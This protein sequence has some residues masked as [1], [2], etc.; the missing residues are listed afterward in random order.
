MNEDNFSPQRENDMIKRRVNFRIAGS[1]CLALE[2]FLTW[3]TDLE[4]EG[5]MTRFTNDDVKYFAEFAKLAMSDEEAAVYA[6]KLSELA[7]FAEELKEVDTEGIAPM[8]HPIPLY[9]VLRE[10]VPVD[11][12]DRE[13][14]LKGIHEHE[15]GQIK[16]PN[17]L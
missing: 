1:G 7:S 9:N 6:E 12:L 16:V 14:M 13:E 2:G 15:D 8:T 4:E 17:I 5:K 11:V 3:I 10:D